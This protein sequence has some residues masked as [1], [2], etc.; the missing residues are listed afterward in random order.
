MKTEEDS[1]E[2]NSP[3]PAPKKKRMTKKMKEAEAAAAKS[4]K[5]KASART[6]RSSSKPTPK[7]TS[8][9]AKTPA[10]KKKSS[11]TNNTPRAGAGD[12]GTSTVDVY[13]VSGDFRSFTI[14]RDTTASALRQAY[15][16]AAGLGGHLPE[17]LQL[18]HRGMTVPE[19]T[20]LSTLGTNLHFQMILDLSPVKIDLM[21]GIVQ[22]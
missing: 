19:E 20:V 21:D 13:G 16:D 6:T 11:K 8:R 2:E 17:T 3:E 14:G 7:A 4:S 18:Y 15:I 9:K 10:S 5:T 12:G 22:I 1:D